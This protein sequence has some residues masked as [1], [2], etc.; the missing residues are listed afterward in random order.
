MKYSTHRNDEEERFGFLI[1]TISEV[2]NVLMQMPIKNIKISTG[3]FLIALFLLPIVGAKA[4]NDL[5]RRR[6]FWGASIAAPGKSPGA[7]VRQVESASPADKAGLKQGDVIAQINGKE[8]T[9]ALTYAATFRAVRTDDKVSLRVVRQGKT[10]D[11]QIVPTPLRRETLQGVAVTYGSVV[12]ERNHRL[13]TIITKPTGASG[14]RLP[15]ILFV[16][17]LSCDSVEVLNNPSDGVEKTLRALASKSGYV[18]MRV[19]RPGLGDSEGPDCSQSNLQDDLAGFRA[20]FAALK[21]YDF[22]DTNNLFVF[23]ASIGGAL[24]PIIAQGENVRGLIVTGA[25]AKTWYEHMLELERRRLELAG[26]P[27]AEVNDAMRG[28]S[29]FYSMY[30][31]QK[32]TPAEVIR[33]RPRLSALWYDQPAHQYGRPAAYFQQVQEL[34]VEAAWEKISAPVFVIYGEYDWIMNRADNDLI[35]QIVNRKKPGN[36]RLLIVPKAGHG[37]DAFETQQAAF[38]GDGGK[39]DENIADQMIEWVRSIVRSGS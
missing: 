28:F 24:A 8:M 36:A 15:A 29:E 23:G 5:L 3:V 37:L 21:T 20:A 22:V 12:T 11:L 4:Q 26:R 1:N 19:E 31:N 39:F 2:E 35:V 27:P 33:Q 14:R 18:L 6:A 7:T 9:D 17:W 10:L 32:L 38:G 34:N 30:L 16:Q 25:F 13:R